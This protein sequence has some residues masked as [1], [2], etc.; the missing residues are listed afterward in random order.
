MAFKNNLLTNAE[1]LSRLLRAA[2]S[3][4]SMTLK[5]SDRA[6]IKR[7]VKQA[8]DVSGSRL[9][10]LLHKHRHGDDGLLV[11]LRDEQ[12][13]ATVG[14]MLHKLDPSMYELDREDEYV[15]LFCRDAIYVE[16]LR[17]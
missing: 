11:R 15:E 16:D 14:P 17:K 7:L 2:L 9:M 13:V 6:A 3:A 10:V 4:A 8:D 5:S 12:D 1:S